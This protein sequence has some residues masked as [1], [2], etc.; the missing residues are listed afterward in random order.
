M[1]EKLS[2]TEL[3]L[4]IRDSLYMALPDMYWVIAEISEIKENSSGHCY[5]DLIEKNSDNDNIKA[6]IKA[7]IW[8]SRY[9]FFKS[10]FENST[11]DTLKAGI[12][13][14]VRVKIEYHEFYGLSLIVADIDPSFTI[15]EI[16]SQRRKIINRLEEEG[17]LSMNKDLHFPVN[18]Q[19]IAI[20]SSSN[21]AGYTDFISHLKGNIKGFVFY[22][23][24]VETA[25]QGKETENDV[26]G[27]LNLIADNK[28]LF[29][30]VVIIRGGGSQS[31]LSW[32]DKYNIAYY[33]TQFPLP[34]LTGIGHEKDLSV[35]DLVAYKSLKTPTAVADF[36]L[37]R[38]QITMDNLQEMSISLM[39]HSKK[40]LDNEKQHIY[41][42][43]L[44]IIPQSQEAFSRM[45]NKLN[46]KI[47]ELVNSG[48]KELFKARIFNSD[49]KS[50]L[51]LLSRTLL[52]NCILDSDRQSIRLKSISPKLLDSIDK[53]IKILENSLNI[54]KP[55]N[56]LKRGYTITSKSNLILKTNQKVNI[57]DIIETR[58][59]DGTI[60]SIITSKNN[61]IDK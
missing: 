51:M 43:N 46:Q 54:L 53:R 27:A 10:F 32:F 40:I 37:E 45:N 52:N 58:F 4:I 44:R 26:I 15:G 6:H 23:A 56:V 9:G 24:L 16:A 41:S 19:R 28:E 17:V 47:I 21:A 57:N 55:E 48:K 13:I 49:H 38:M 36:I 50:K 34:V 8:N 31:D 30:I 2:L 1:D 12:K 3:Q 18:P 5:L 60:T 42:I 29:D 35:S 20:I 25:M 7:I 11:G 33:I 61:D 22:T 59:A 14:L 39:N